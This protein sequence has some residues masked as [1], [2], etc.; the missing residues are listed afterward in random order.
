MRRKLTSL[1][2]LAFLG[3]GAIAYAQTQGIVNDSNGFPE[4]D[5]EVQI[6]GKGT[7]VFTDENGAFSID[8]K[9]GDVLIIDGNE[10]IVT[11][12]NLGTIAPKVKKDD[13]ELA[14]TVVTAYGTQKKETIV[15]S[16]STVS[17]KDIEDR[18]LTNVSNAL[19]GTV[20]GVRVEG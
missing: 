13:I 17:A 15:G 18:P 8:A 16:V 19:D 5:I 20:T 7:T 12:N 10:V 14:E 1:S 3:F 11:S 9:I 4:M 6:K 2:F